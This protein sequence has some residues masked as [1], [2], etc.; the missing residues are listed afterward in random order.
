MNE[1]LW[2]RVD[3][4]RSKLPGTS[5]PAFEAVLPAIQ[6]SSNQGR[7]LQLLA[8]TQGARGSWL[9]FKTSGRTPIAWRPWNPVAW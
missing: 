9:D 7:L 2:H 6:I 1:E 4:F 5:D 8:Q 3:D